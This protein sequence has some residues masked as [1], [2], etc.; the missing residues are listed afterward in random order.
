MLSQDNNKMPTINKHG[1]QNTVNHDTSIYYTYD[2][3]VGS[4]YCHYL[5]MYYIMQFTSIM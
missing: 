1:L 2:I 3:H 4:T 5:P